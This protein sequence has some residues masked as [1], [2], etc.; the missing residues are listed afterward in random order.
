MPLG[1]AA[2]LTQGGMD[3]L[4]RPVV[5]RSPLL[6]VAWL[7]GP[8]AVQGHVADRWADA[9]DDPPASWF[10][11]T[12]PPGAV[13]MTVRI[14]GDLTA[15]V[16]GVET[17]LIAGRLPLREH[18]RVA[19]R[20]QSVAG[21]RGAACFLEHPIF[22]LGPGTIRVGTSWHRQGLD[23]FS[24]VIAHSADVDLDHDGEAI[25]DLGRVAGSVSVTVNGENA[26]VLAWAPWRLPVNIRRGRNVIEIEVAN[27]LGAMVSRGIPTP[28]GPE[29]QRI[30]GLLERPRLLVPTRE[31][32]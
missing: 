3:Q 16:E 5:R 26:G 19:L 2:A 1:V 20:V 18:A 10:A 9:P 30:S 15:Y 27:T 24:G 17:Q 12:A 21:R 4:D 32:G 22:E 28:F 31:Q 23:V 29:D 6:D 7:E 14:E 8:D 13:S 25:L 11:F